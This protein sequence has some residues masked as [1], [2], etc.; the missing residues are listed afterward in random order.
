MKYRGS[1]VI[2]AILA[3]VF[4]RG[5]FGQPPYEERESLILHGVLQ[6]IEQVHYNPKPLDDE[7]SKDVF[8]TYL[9]RIDGGKR[10]FTQ[11]DIDQM[12]KYR[13]EL[14]DQ[15][16]VR[17]F[18]FF[19]LSL[20]L[21]D[22]RMKEAKSY[23]DELIDKDYDFTLDEFT[24]LDETKKPWAAN[25][26][27]LK[28]YWKEFLKYEIMTTVARDLDAQEKS[29]TIEQ[30]TV[31]VLEEEAKDDIK[32][33]F[34]DWFKRLEA[35]R[36]SDRF[37]TYVGTITNYFDPHTGYF[38]PKEK[39]DFDI[40]MGGKLE[41]IGARLRQQD[42]YIQ[43]VEII[44]GGPAWK[45]KELEVDDKFLSVT[46]EGGEPVDVVGMRTDD[47]IPMIR[48]KKGTVVILSILKPDGSIVNI[49]IE[50]DEVI[51]DESFARSAIIDIPDMIEN[52]GYI[53][54][55]KFY[56]SFEKEDGNS[57]AKDVAKE[58]EKLK[59]NN[60]NGIIL[61]LRN[62][63]GGSLNDVV[64]MS[65]LFIEKGP[66][67]QVK[68][69]NSKA[70]V[71]S[72]TDPMVQYDG[73]LIVMV[74]TNSASASEIL[75]AA[76]QDYGRAIIIG[77]NSTF[78]K[79]SVQR[80]YDLDRAIKGND[81]LKPLGNIKMSVQKFFRVNGGSTQLKGV[82]PDV[83]LPDNYSYIDAGEKEYDNVL[84]WDEIEAKTYNQDVV[85]ITNMSGIVSNSKKRTANN[86][87]FLLAD[88][89][90]KLIKSNRDIT[91]Y[92]L[93]IN[94]FRANRKQQEADAE[95]FNSLF[96]KDIEKIKLSNLP[97]D[98]DYINADES[99]VGRNEE[100]FKGLK[101][102]FYLEETLFVM[103]DMIESEP[104]FANIA[105]K[106]KSKG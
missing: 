35:L 4:G 90:A 86:D 100:W 84:P 7:F 101:K 103:K 9:E 30:K 13:L 40:N 16:K 24:E 48:G 31:A 44:A 56:S 70:Y 26:E 64:D 104:S 95:K 80:F 29:D 51:I 82:I 92:S 19:D 28:G 61:D 15:S 102:D 97:E 73:P 38:N 79:G 62:N 20:E 66:I 98:I 23:Y 55:P 53:K 85:K 33:K 10:Y 8:D 21:L 106:I 88:G 74:N 18:E 36:R 52:V 75:A 2:I 81:E 72:D 43:V 47:A 60:V 57:C 94:T 5:F 87:N 32:E 99:R 54:L 69:K 78:G 25:S 58:L 83:I 14:D 105:D 67:V 3:F 34:G 42:D 65:G 89:R 50:R 22:K 39:E 1:I 93:N 59:A 37:E 11:E 71:H 68:S 12:S 96:K 41:G 46:Q 63:T 6:F 27:E 49:K 17:T 77:G 45:G 76:M 91:K